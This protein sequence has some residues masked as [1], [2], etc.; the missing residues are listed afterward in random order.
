M[1]RTLKDLIIIE[2]LVFLGGMVCRFILFPLIFRIDGNAFYFKTLGLS[3]IWGAAI[4]LV[5]LVLG[6]FLS[7]KNS[8][9]AWLAVLPL[10]VAVIFT[11]IEVNYLYNRK[12][13]STT[14]FL[15]YLFS[16]TVSIVEVGW[17]VI[18][19]A[20]YIVLTGAALFVWWYE[21]RE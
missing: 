18:Q 15:P 8:R 17:P 14:D 12:Y 4:V 16:G 2:C 9:I 1:A 21:G 7:K 13:L 6:L 19:Y 10:G 20:P 5:L 3:L 11:A